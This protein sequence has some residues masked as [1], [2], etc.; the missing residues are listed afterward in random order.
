MEYLGAENVH[1]FFLFLSPSMYVIGTLEIG[2]LN[3]IAHFEQP[4]HNGLKN[5]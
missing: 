5:E 1:I 2:K 3:L 4:Y